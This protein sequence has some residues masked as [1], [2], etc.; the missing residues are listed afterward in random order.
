M[1][2]N[3][4]IH[5]YKNVP[6]NSVRY[7]VYLE[8]SDAAEPFQPKAGLAYNSPGLSLYYTKNRTAPVPVALVDLTSAQDVWTSGGVKEVDSVNLPGLVRFDLPNDVFKGDQKSSE[9]LVTIKATGFRT[10]TVRIPLV[11]NV[12]DASP[13]GVVSAVPYAGWKNQTVRTDN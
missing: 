9:V 12:Q 1:S 13:K 7:S 8:M 11:D 4:T 2:V 6:V 10:L 5:H 3:T